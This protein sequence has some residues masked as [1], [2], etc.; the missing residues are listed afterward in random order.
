MNPSGHARQ[1]PV[2]IF[3][4]FSRWTGAA[5]LTMFLIG[6]AE[7]A[8]QYSR[9]SHV[10]EPHAPGTNSITIHVALA[11]AAAATVTGVQVWR[12]RHPARRGPSPWAAPFSASALARLGRTI[13]SAGWPPQ[14][15]LRALATMALLVVQAYWPLMMGQHLTGDLDPNQAVNAW[16]GPSYL[17]AVLAHW[18]DGIVIFYAVGLLL[19][20]VLLP[21]AAQGLARR[22]AYR[23]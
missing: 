14:N 8:V 9:R 1:R 23:P 22:D 20:W 13:Q 3:C 19:N 2:I 16:G 4:R 17:G 15:M 10:S 12:S 7:G 18:L 5:V 11:I 6:I 21:S